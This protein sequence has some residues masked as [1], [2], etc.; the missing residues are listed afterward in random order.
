MS[1]PQFNPPSNYPRPNNNLSN[2]INLPFPTNSW[3]QEALV[4]N[5]ADVDRVGKYP[6]QGSKF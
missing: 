4:D 1:Y 3:F 5:I 2:N 6:W